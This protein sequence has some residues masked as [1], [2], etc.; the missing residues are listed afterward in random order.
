M[1][2]RVEAV[3]G[4]VLLQGV[5]LGAADACWVLSRLPGVTIDQLRLLPWA[6]DPVCKLSFGGSGLELSRAGGSG[7]DGYLLASIGAVPEPTIAELAELLRAR[8]LISPLW[9]S[10]ALALSMGLLA[11]GGLTAG[12]GA[13]MWASGP[14]PSQLGTVGGAVSATVVGAALYRTLR[15]L[16]LRPGKG[17]RG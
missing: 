4:G 17:H 3:E 14:G 8:P 15:G 10:A 7:E 6:S 1:S 2:L 13:F 12:V 5:W 9:P 11:V 16:I